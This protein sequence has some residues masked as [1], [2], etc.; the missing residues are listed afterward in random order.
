MPDPKW[1]VDDKNLAEYIKDYQITPAS[2]HIIGRAH[3]HIAELRTALDDAVE[4]LATHH[5][6]Q[7]RGL[8]AILDREEPPEAS[9][10]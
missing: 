5:G 1:L 10:E 2:M 4:Q 6:G 3:A 7:W 8:D 9:N